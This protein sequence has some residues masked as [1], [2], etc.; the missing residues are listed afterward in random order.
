MTVGFQLRHLSCLAEITFIRKNRIPN[1]S[2]IH[3]IDIIYFR[4]KQRIENWIRKC[5][6]IDHIVVSRLF[7]TD[8]NQSV[9]TIKKTISRS[10]FRALSFLS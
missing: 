4:I 9:M 5:N 8:R 1:K 2:Y 6:V 10:Q 3:R 7:F